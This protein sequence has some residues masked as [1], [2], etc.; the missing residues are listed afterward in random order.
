MG[1]RIPFSSLVGR[2]LVEENLLRTHFPSA[3]VCCCSFYTN[4]PTSKPTW[5]AYI[6]QSQQFLLA[7]SFLLPVGSSRINVGCYLPAENSPYLP[8]S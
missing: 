4:P 1:V 2:K 5:L 3:A 7:C 6:Y 8:G